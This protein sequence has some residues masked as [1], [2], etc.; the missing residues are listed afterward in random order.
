LCHTCMHI[1]CDGCNAFIIANDSSGVYTCDACGNTFCMYCAMDCEYHGPHCTTDGCANNIVLWHGRCHRCKRDV[2]NEE[3]AR[4]D[5]C[6]RQH[7][8][9]CTKTRR[10]SSGEVYCVDCYN[11][12]ALA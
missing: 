10:S 11:E 3:N 8:S 5:R 2:N 12:K 1:T 6:N 9:E 4:C 7:C